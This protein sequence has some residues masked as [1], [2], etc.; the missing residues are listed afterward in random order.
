[1]ANLKLSPWLSFPDEVPQFYWAT[2]V[3]IWLLPAIGLFL[4]IRDRHRWMLDANI[5]MAIVTMLANSRTSA[6]SRSPGIRFCS[7]S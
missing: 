6:P 1:M 5:V 3:A 7:A 4:A 2:Y